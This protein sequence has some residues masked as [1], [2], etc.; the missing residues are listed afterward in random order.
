MTRTQ[1]GR[2]RAARVTRQ[3]PRPRRPSTKRA[4]LEAARRLVERRGLDGFT[5]WELAGEVPVSEAAIFYHFGDRESLLLEL[6]MELM[7]EEFARLREAA[8]G[9]PDVRSAM[10]AVLRERVR[11]YEGRINA[12]ELVHFWAFPRWP[13]R[14]RQQAGA[15]VEAV[16]DAIEERAGP[17]RAVRRTARP[18]TLRRQIVAAW[19]AGDGLALTQLRVGRGQI[20]AK[21]GIVVVCDEICRFATHALPAPSGRGARG[22]RREGR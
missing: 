12:L 11:F 7:T 20:A 3:G 19:V 16:W 17:R 14:L 22:R 10:E 4:I 6:G 8:S 9:A 15:R 18:S 13:P 21:G 5:T 2:K 1:S